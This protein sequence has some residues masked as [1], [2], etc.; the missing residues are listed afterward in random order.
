M[1]AAE[2]TALVV[3][4]AATVALGLLVGVVLWLARAVRARRRLVKETSRQRK[5]Q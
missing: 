1:S 2:V 4:V 5:S 3:A